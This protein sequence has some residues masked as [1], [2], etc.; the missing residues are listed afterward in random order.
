MPT[1]DYPSVKVAPPAN[2]QYRSICYYVSLREPG[3]CLYYIASTMPAAVQWHYQLM[4]MM[5]WVTSFMLCSFPI[6][7]WLTCFMGTIILWII[8]ACIL[9]MGMLNQLQTEQ[10]TLSL[11]DK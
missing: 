8:D 5:P 3:P 9:L 10:M 6:R 7:S 11:N 4:C 1:R 2:C